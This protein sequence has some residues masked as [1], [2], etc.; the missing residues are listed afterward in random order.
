MVTNY[1][2]GS[3][4]VFKIGRDGLIEEGMEMFV[5]HEGSGPNVDRQA[6]AHP[7]SSIFVE[8]DQ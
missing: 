5:M 6:S 7:H 2:S 8:K 3:F 4:V 1:T